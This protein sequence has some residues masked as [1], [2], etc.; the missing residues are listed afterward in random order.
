[1]IQASLASKQT[2][3]FSRGGNSQ[4]NSRHSSAQR[5]RPQRL[6]QP[7]P[8]PKQ[9]RTE[10]QIILRAGLKIPERGCVVLDQPKQLP[11]FR[12][13]GVF[14]PCC[15][16]SSTPRRSRFK[17]ALGVGLLLFAVAGGPAAA[18][19]TDPAASFAFSKALF[20]HVNENDAKAAIKIYSQNIADA[21]QILVGHAPMLLD[22]TNAI[23][24]A[25]KLQQV[26]VFA[27]TAEE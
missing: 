20:K 5:N 7:G 8:T 19:T 23:A 11:K 27:L 18:E 9:K 14:S 13:L 4:A 1:M 10:A 25:I 3:L 6:L 17:Q 16:W 12:W 26:D 21:N 2:V 22:D 24:K 15:G